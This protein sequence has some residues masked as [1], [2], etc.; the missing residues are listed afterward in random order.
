MNM[1]EPHLVKK[2]HI[3]HTSTVM[4]EISQQLKASLEERYIA[5][6]SYLNIYRARREW[7]LMKSIL[8]KLRKEQLI[9]RVTDKSGTF[10]IGPDIDHEKKAMAYQER[11][12]A[13]VELP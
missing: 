7:T 1:I 10:H 5:P 6:L 2:H 11:T 4:K 13:Y 3:P 9:L 12:K 8:R